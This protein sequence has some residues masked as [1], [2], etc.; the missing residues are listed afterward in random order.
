[1]IWATI[2]SQSCF[3]CL[4][5]AS[6]SSTANN[7]INLISILTIWVMSMCRIVSCVVGRE[8][9]PW[10]VC[11]LGKILLASALL[12]FILQDKICLLLQLSLDFLLFH[13]SPLWWKG[14]L[15]L[16]LV[17]KDL[18]GLHRTVQL[19]FLQHYWL[20][21]RLGLLWHWMVCLGNEQRSFCRFWDFIQ[22][23]HFRLSRWLWWL[24]HFF[25]GIPARSSRY[26]DHL[27]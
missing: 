13:S 7:R 14:H 4:Y 6:P 15:F 17:L 18:V 16:V 8:C 21:H 27:S 26:N 19:Q 25:Y 9:F 24:L 11:F 20:G 10:L 5:S 3:C 12:H 22:V 1:M 23:L 2:S